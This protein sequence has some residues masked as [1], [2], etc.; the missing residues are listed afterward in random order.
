MGNSNSMSI[1]DLTPCSIE[2]VR[3]QFMALMDE[4]ARNPRPDAEHRA[5][6]LDQLMRDYR[7]RNDDHDNA[8]DGDDTADL[9]ERDDGGGNDDHDNA[10]DGD[11]TPTL[12]ISVICVVSIILYGIFL[13]TR[14]L[15]ISTSDGIG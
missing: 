3:T 5:M 4:Q 11:E 15:G 14:S 8:M 13:W 1:S 7:E 12:N 10:M 9:R 2:R 6:I